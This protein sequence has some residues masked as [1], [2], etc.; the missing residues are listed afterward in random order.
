MKKSLLLITLCLFL[1]PPTPVLGADTREFIGTAETTDSRESTGTTDSTE[2]TGTTE[3]LD[4]A[5][6]EKKLTILFTH[7]QHSNLT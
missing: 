4:D 3:S 5:M 7:D 6:N 1:L 2:S